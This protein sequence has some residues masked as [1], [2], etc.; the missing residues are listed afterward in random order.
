MTINGTSPADSVAFEEGALA[1]GGQRLYYLRLMPRKTTAD[2]GPT[3]VFLH[4]ALGCTAMWHDFPAQVVNDTG[5]PAIVYDR[6]GYGRST[7]L[8]HHQRDK[9]YLHQEAEVVLPQLLAQLQIDRAVLIGHSDGGSIALL[10]AA[11][12]PAK[13]VGIVTEAAHV[14]VESITRQ[15]IRE[16]LAA[17]EPRGLEKR[18]ARYHGKRTQGLFFAWADTWLSPAFRDWN[19]ED[20]LGRIQC[21][22]LIIQGCEDQYGSQRQVEAIVTGIGAR[23]APLLIPDCGH[24]P[25]RDAP[26]RVRRAIADFIAS[27]P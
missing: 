16:A 6:A 24:A 3:L 4:E 5:L 8:A 9:F 12:C 18:L 21:A 7:P 1:L 20:C 10:T 17:Y 14:F 22:S 27:L 23:A 11:A 15:G 26:R 13:V 25:H 2:S 19:I